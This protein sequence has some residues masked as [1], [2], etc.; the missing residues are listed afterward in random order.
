[1]KGESGELVLG[2]YRIEHPM[3]HG[4]FGRI[5]VGRQVSLHRK[6]AIKSVRP[7]LAGAAAMRERFRREAVVAASI[8]H[9]NVVTYHEFGVD[10]D[11][12][13]ILVME[14]L[15]GWTVL[16]E[17][18]KRPRTPARTTAR[19]IG[20][21]AAGLGAAHEAGIVH[22]DVK[23]SNLFLVAP[24][25]DDE[26][27]K[28]I[29]FGILRVTADADG[30]L[31][32]LE[33]LTC[34]DA[35]IGTPE[36]AAPE[37]ILGQEVDG[38]A[39]QYALALVAHLMLTG[40]K[41]FVGRDPGALLARVS[42]R[43][44]L[45]E[46][47]ADGAEGLS[48]PVREVLYRALTPDPEGRYPTIVAFAEALDA[49]V[50]AGDGEG[51]WDCV[52]TDVLEGVTT[53]GAS[54][55]SG[56]VLGETLVTAD[57]V[58]VGGA[59]TPGSIRMP[60]RRRTILWLT[61]GLVSLAAVATGGVLAGRHMAAP[62]NLNAETANKSPAG[63]AGGEPDR[64]A[65][66]APAPATD[67]AI[68]ADPAIGEPEAGDKRSTDDM[69]PE[70]DKPVAVAVEGPVEAVEDE[71]AP[72]EETSP[73][74]VVRH[75][76]RSKH[77]SRPRRT[78]AVSHPE[79][80]DTVPAVAPREDATLTFNAEPWAD[81]RLDG[82][83]LGTTPV[84]SVKVAPGT[85]RVEFRHPELGVIREAPHVRPGESRT[86]KVRFRE[87]GGGGVSPGASGGS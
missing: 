8:N 37:M 50:V 63:V 29:D 3:G 10:E 78:A 73:P 46:S 57:S 22:R 35:F 33:D 69:P 51:T 56:R 87:V 71:D 32:D 7:E 19:R 44:D 86:V 25:R 23:P 83:V 49:A 6:V 42:R 66:S 38:R 36:Y 54:T 48:G 28:V 81:V 13:L 2:R 67:R 4:G 43:P 47:P 14:L 62:F 17:L 52:P 12:D 61:V 27:I 59:S 84:V 45:V 53:P 72:P 15:K 60:H 55:P 21:A 75:R 64:D 58:D 70:D 26:R 82:R 5:H 30:A 20:Q 1:M 39:D 74:V 11:G 79:G 41:G 18:R 16:E 9:P 24:G 40:R 68:G 76:V 31:A 80:L 77:P 65:P 85:H 34:S